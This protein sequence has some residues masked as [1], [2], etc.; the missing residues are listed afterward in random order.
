MCFVDG[1]E[2]GNKNLQGFTRSTVTYRLF[3]LVLKQNVF[4]GKAVAVSI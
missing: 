4:E 3:C 1:V 2:R